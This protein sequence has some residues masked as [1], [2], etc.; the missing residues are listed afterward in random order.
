MGERSNGK[1]FVIAFFETRAAGVTAARALAEPPASGGTPRAV[2][3]LAGAGGDPEVSTFGGGR[4]DDLQGVARLLGVIGSALLGGVMPP[5]SHFLDEGSELTTDDISR[6]GAELEAGHAAVAILEERVLAQ[7][8][9]VR[10]VELG[11]RTEVHR[12]TDHAVRQA[13]TMPPLAS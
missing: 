2:G 7:R 8:S 13:G 12:L 11:G 1:R 10:L 9:V 3:V 5:R 4:A 6:I